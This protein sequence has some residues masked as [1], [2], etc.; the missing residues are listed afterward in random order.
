MRICISSLVIVAQLVCAVFFLFASDAPMRCRLRVD[1]AGAVADGDG[2]V[3]VRSASNNLY[4][5]V[6]CG[7]C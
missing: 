1:T 6:D 5:F 4:R 7:V 2:V 3:A